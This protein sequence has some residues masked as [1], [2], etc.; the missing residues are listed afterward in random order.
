MLLE[1]Y[2]TKW[3]ET[4][5]LQVQ[6]QRC[7]KTRNRF[8]TCHK[9]VDICPV[10]AIS[11]E[12]GLSVQEDIC[13]ECM[14]CTVHCP[15]EA[16]SDEKYVEYFKEMSNREVIAFSCENDKRED[17]SIKLGCLYQLDKALLIQA[18]TQSKKVSIQFDEKRCTKCVKYHNPDKDL[19][20]SLDILVEELNSMLKEPIN[21][22]YNDQNT[23]KME[24][25]YTRRELITFFSKKMTRNVVSPLITE[26]EEVR[27]LRETVGSGTIRETYH[28]LLRKYQNHFKQVQRIGDINTAQLNFNEKC[29]GCKV[30]ERVCPMGALKFSE[31]ESIFT[32]TLNHQIC[33]GC[34]SCVD[35]CRKGALEINNASFIDLQTF[36]KGE[37]QVVLT[38][39]NN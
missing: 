12:G 9:C 31:D 4:K 27:N 25:N 7:I 30:C 17:P 19:K 38:K 37:E 34:Q 20:S 22:D 33:N 13:T 28:Y 36:L 11:F 6:P 21:I 5:R 2:V 39:E 32:A 3:L 23:S 18:C 10:S 29:D 26:E 1:R 35:I 14:R 24:R 16:F 8:S 15:S